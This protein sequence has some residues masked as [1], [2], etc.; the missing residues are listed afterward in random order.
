[1]ALGRYLRQAVSRYRTSH[2]PRR[3]AKSSL[4]N[5]AR[6]LGAPF[7]KLGMVASGES[8]NAMNGLI[9]MTY[10]RKPWLTQAPEPYR[11]SSS[12]ASFMTLLLLS[13]ALSLL[14]VHALA[15]EVSPSGEILPEAL[16]PTTIVASPPSAV[17]PQPDPAATEKL[18]A[19]AK[20][21]IIW[22][23]VDGRWHWHCVAHC[24]KFRTHD[25]SSDEGSTDFSDSSTN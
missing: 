22:H 1:M 14:A 19:D 9:I 20:P 2:V 18:A 13:G 25:E 16:P 4:R 5:H 17:S 23:Q 8:K 21:S 3:L 11:L 7:A 6:M 15:Q 10:R 12:R 24:S